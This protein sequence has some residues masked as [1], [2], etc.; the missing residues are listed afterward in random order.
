MQDKREPAAVSADWERALEGLDFP[1]SK[2]ALVR[3]E[4]DRG[5][6]DSEVRM[7]LKQLPADGYDTHDELIAAIRAQYI[8]DGFAAGSLPL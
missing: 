1:I 7:I 5:G 8:D 3:A 4:A 2:I 6:I